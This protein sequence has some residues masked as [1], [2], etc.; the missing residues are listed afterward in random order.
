MTCTIWSALDVI[1]NPSVCNLVGLFLVR[2][3]DHIR[4]FK[5]CMGK[6]SLGEWVSM[7]EDMQVGP[8]TA[9][10]RI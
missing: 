5:S 1:A 4:W 9:S 10:A 7:G 3:Q 8:L 6:L 2:F